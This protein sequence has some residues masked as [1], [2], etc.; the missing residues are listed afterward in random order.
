MRPLPLRFT[1]RLVS[2]AL[3]VWAFTSAHAAGQTAAEFL[4]RGLECNRQRQ[5]ERA[6]SDFS[7]PLP[8]GDA[9]GSPLGKQIRPSSTSARPSGSTR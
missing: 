2:T 8:P 3:A 5:F 6:I 1:T 7:M 9:F 4:K